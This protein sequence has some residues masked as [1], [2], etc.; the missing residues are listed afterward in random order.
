MKEKK[1]RIRILLPILFMMICFNSNAQTIHPALMVWYVGDETV[2]LK[3]AQSDGVTAT[4]SLKIEMSFIKDDFKSFTGDE[5]TFEVK[6]YFFM[7]TRKTL[8]ATNT[9]SINRF[10]ADKDGILKM[11]GEKKNTRKGWWEVQIKCKNND[12]LIKYAG[13]TE[14]QILL[15]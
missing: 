13:K 4:T 3:Q 15:K 6:W 10:Q 8:M 11:T 5:I 9:I 1:M 12:E 2:T 14:Y 7:S